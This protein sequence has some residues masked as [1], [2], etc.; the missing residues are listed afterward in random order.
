MQFIRLRSATRFCVSLAAAAVLSTSVLAAEPGDVIMTVDGE[1]IFQRDYDLAAR[2]LGPELAKMGA[3][4]REQVLMDV[5]SET[6]LLARLAEKSG[7]MDTDEYKQ[8]MLF[9]TRRVKRDIYVQKSITEK[10]DDAAIK[11]RYD[12]LIKEFPAG[13]EVKARH[14]LVKTE[15]EA[16][17]IINELNGGADFEK[18]AK[19]KSTG[20]SGPRGG[21]LGYFGKG[22]MVPAFD[23]AVFELEKGKHST[24]P[25]KSNFGWHVIKVDDTRQK[26]P[27]PLEQIK[28]RLSA[29][30]AQE[31]LQELVKDLRTKAKIERV[32]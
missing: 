21:D 27:P 6:L 11:T 23:K 4:Q 19:E 18:L 26:S 3:A 7:T 8:R 28:D 16:K 5:L 31:K 17:A 24:E 25:V 20:P 2:L 9:M 14:I 12:E 10:V 13:P 1:K 30:V 32:K 22:Q 29:L 15:D